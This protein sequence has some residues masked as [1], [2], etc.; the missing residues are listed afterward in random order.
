MKETPSRL[1][2]YKRDC[3]RKIGKDVNIITAFEKGRPILQA[4]KAIFHQGEERFAELD[5]DNN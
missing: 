5:S 1:I 2:N 4:Q 3:F